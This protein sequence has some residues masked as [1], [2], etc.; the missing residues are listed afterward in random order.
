MS[1]KNIEESNHTF[2]F[3]GECKYLEKESVKYIMFVKSSLN[4]H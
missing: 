3:R 2:I 1:R 4:I